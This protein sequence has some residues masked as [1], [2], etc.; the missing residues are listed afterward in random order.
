MKAENL[1][2]IMQRR[3]KKL[4]KEYPDYNN[5]YLVALHKLMDW[6]EAKKAE[7]EKA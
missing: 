4:H 5:N 7:V 3:W 1:E 6:Y 2:K